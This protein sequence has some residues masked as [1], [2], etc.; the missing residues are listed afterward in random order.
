MQCNVKNGV[1]IR[2]IRWV[3]EHVHVVG[4]IPS[5]EDENTLSTPD[6]ILFSSPFFLLISRDKVDAQQD[7]T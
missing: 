5:A 6:L 4:P 2:D 3:E 7:V 1:T